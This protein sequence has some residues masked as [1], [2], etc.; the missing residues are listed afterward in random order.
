V[1]FR[2]LHAA[3][4]HLDT[5]FAGVGA[6]APAV[7][8]A[9]RDA[10][11]GVLDDL[12]RLAVARDVAFVV[13][14]GDLYDGAERGVRAQLAV[15]RAATTLAEHGIRT[16]VAHGNHDPVEEGWSA[17][18]SWPDAVT[19]FPADRVSSV[20]VERD[21]TPLATVHGISYARR[22]TT[23]NLA[24][25]FAR[26]DDPGFHVGVLHANVGG[27]GEHQ[28]YSPCTVDDL[29]WAGLDYWALGHVHRH[30]VLRRDP[31]VVYPGTPQG[32]SP[33]PREQGPKG[34]VLVEVDDGGRVASLELVPLDRVRVT[35]AAVDLAD[36][37]DLP[38]LRDRLVA[39]GRR[40]LL[41]ADGRSVLLRGVVTGRGPLH[42]DLVRPGVVDDLLRALRDDADGSV[43]FAWW[44]RLDVRTGADRDLDDL[45]GRSDF[46]SDLLDEHARL[47]DGDPVARTAGWLDELPSGVARALG[48]A[49]PDPADRGRWDDALELA[50]DLVA[51][52]DGTEP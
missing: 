13:L 43:P 26:T 36:A 51:G 10:S 3:D 38:D 12:V 30:Q 2:F 40:A 39:A 29:A 42:H 9:L 22:D 33:A 15:H 4:L 8:E 11:L 32:R 25:R 5:P 28:P 24:R 45:R 37:D 19:V 16:F 44:H 41:D 46:L 18:R 34:V 48:V 6:A 20:V 21:G 31:W 52:D 47:V 49:T 35:E 27:H 7:A 17:V 23:E 50:V 14:A 1:T